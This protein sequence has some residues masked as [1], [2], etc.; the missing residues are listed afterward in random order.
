MHLE[1]DPETAATVHGMSEIMHINPEEVAKMAV[2]A[3][4]S[5]MA[6]VDTL[7]DARLKDFIKSLREQRP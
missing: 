7:V 5:Q 1:L 2:M 4:G 3:F 6:A